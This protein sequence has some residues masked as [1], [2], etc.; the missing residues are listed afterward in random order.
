MVVT[1]FLCIRM[2]AWRET[3]FAVVF[4][5]L[6]VAGQPVAFVELAAAND[7]PIPTSVESD[8]PIEYPDSITVGE[9]AT[10]RIV[11]ENEGGRAGH[12]ST[13]TASFP[14]LDET[15]DDQQV[16]VTSHDFDTNGYSN[17]MAAGDYAYDKHGNYEE[18]S[19]AMVE[20]GKD[21]DGYWEGSYTEHE[22]TVEVT[23]EETGTFVAYV[24]VTM[25]DD[26]TTEKFNWPSS[27]GYY[28][29]QSYE[30]YR[31]EIDVEPKKGNLEVYADDE[32]DNDAD[33]ASVALYDDSWNHLDT[34]NANTY[35]NADWYDKPIG[36]Y[37]VEVYGD[38]GSFWGSDTVDINEDQTTYSY[39]DRYEP[40]ET[41]TA[42]TDQGDGDGTH[43]VGET[44]NISP[45]IKTTGRQIARSA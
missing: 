36:T 15:D 16:S 13:I 17:M 38:R 8:T 5:V 22:M 34:E 3:V 42:I 21:G 39:I 18:L 10:I 2:G 1:C 28:D 23:P 32:N 11:G 9:S 37:H 7:D 44:V 31:I 29:Q 4:A 35:G 33:D 43:I 27:T 40:Y 45:E 12:W 19:Y 14:S 30:V 6:L 24:R 20:A 25:T 41:Q 26:D